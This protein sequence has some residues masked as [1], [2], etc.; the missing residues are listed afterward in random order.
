MVG[1]SL[2]GCQSNV[3]TRRSTHPLV[4]VGPVTLFC[5]HFATCADHHL[6]SHN[7]GAITCLLFASGQ[8]LRCPL[9]RLCS[10]DG[11]T[12][13]IRPYLQN[14]LPRYIMVWGAI[15]Y[16]SRLP[17]ICVQ[18]NMTSQRYEDDILQ[19]VALHFQKNNASSA[20]VFCKIYKSYLIQ[21]VWDM[22][23]HHVNRCV[24]APLR[25]VDVPWK[26]V[27]QRM[28]NHPSEHH[29]FFH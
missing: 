23:E 12:I 4:L 20:N 13:P 27:D 25:S 7:D 2:R 15:A 5:L 16:D 22:V 28:E 10:T 3:S 9:R 8:H 17:P 21:Y 24:H 1:T 26:I 14:A 29:S 18:C 6:C 11:V 19:P